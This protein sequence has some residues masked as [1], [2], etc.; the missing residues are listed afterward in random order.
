M[1]RKRKPI[2]ELDSESLLDNYTEEV[3]YRLNVDD[4]KDFYWYP[5]DELKEEL[6]LRLKDY[7]GKV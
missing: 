2:V 1:G 4:K 7:E 6:L 3:L 5:L